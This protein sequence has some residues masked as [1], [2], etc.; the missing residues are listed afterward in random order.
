MLALGAIAAAI[1]ISAGVI[2]VEIVAWLVAGPL[3][4]GR[5]ADT[6]PTT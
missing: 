1:I 3:L 5:S 4:K 6:N 2:V